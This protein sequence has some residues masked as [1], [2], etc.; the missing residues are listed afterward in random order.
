MF[1]PAIHEYDVRNS[2]DIS[3]CV[4][5]LCELL[6]DQDSLGSGELLASQ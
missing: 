2:W 4:V 5:Y 1:E 6:L 3:L